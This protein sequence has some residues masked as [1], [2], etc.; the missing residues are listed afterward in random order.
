[1]SYAKAN[2][3]IISTFPLREARNDFS[4]PIS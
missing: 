4:V 3:R 1:V 2:F